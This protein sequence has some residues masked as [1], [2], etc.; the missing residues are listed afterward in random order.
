[1]PELPV[2]RNNRLHVPFLQLSPP[3]LLM[4]ALLLLQAQRIAAPLPCRCHCLALLRL[5]ECAAARAPCCQLHRGLTGQSGCCH[6]WQL[7]Q[8]HHLL[9]RLNN[10]QIAYEMESVFVGQKH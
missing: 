3:H 6:Q 2:Q 10:M 8:Q 9:L 5:G 4:H 1:M 7:A